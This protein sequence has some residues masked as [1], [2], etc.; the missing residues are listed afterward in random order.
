M[1]NSV[2][3]GGLSLNLRERVRSQLSFLRHLVRMPLGH[4]P[5]EVF[6][7]CLTGRNLKADLGKK[8][9]TSSCS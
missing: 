9:W 7:T 2:K 1:M 5:W 3:L 6:Q 4:I 8:H